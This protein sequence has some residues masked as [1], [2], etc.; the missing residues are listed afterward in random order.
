[1]EKRENEFFKK[2]KICSKF[3]K[4]YLKQIKLIKYSFTISCILYLENKLLSTFFNI[5]NLIY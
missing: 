2:I 1:M 4:Y 3:K 5:K